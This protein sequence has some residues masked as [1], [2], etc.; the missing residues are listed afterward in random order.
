MSDQITARDR[1]LIDEAIAA[2]M[3]ARVPT[4]ISSFSLQRWDPVVG[5]LRS[6][7]GGCENSYRGRKAKRLH[8]DV[9]ARRERVRA[10]VDKGAT[11]TEIARRLRAAPATITQDL[12]AL[13]AAGR[14]DTQKGRPK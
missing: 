3:V 1:A 9:A 7:G 8:P 6:D 5:R 11:P 14:I 12:A 13:R 4:G 2:G 10:L